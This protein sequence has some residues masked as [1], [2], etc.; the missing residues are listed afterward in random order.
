MGQGKI[1]A[2]TK[3]SIEFWRTDPRVRFSVDGKK[4]SAA[5][6][7]WLFAAGQIARECLS[8]V[9]PKHWTIENIGQSYGID[10]RTSIK[11]FANFQQISLVGK[12]PDGR[13]F[14]R[15][16]RDRHSKLIGWRELAPPLPGPGSSSI[17]LDKSR[18]VI[19]E[20]AASP[21]PEE[22][23]KP[24]LKENFKKPR[25]EGQSENDQKVAEIIGIWNTH[26]GVDDCSPGLAGMIGGLARDMDRDWLALIPL[27]PK[28]VAPDKRVGYLVRMRQNG[29][30]SA[31]EHG[32]KYEVAM[33]RLFGVKQQVRGA[34]TM[35][36]IFEGM[37]R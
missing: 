29:L 31:L 3:E 13:L 15:G 2:Y 34:Q 36:R 11:S 28:G 1:E 26:F 16:V 19:K 21:Q 20:L 6:K 9:L 23:E 18:E 17:R 25:S 24:H 12:M 37:Q 14:V 32:P 8:E 27:I 30:P 5:V 22:K 10:R 33:K 7:W 35:K 4:L